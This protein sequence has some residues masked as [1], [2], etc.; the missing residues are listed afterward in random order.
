MQNKTHTLLSH[1]KV[2]AKNKKTD[3]VSGGQAVEELELPTGR[4]VKWLRYF[5]RL[6][7]SFL[8]D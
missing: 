1:Y 7:R 2:L 8:Q 5:G 6:F 4:S 3:K